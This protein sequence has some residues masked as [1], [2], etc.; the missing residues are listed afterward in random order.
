MAGLEALLE[1]ACAPGRHVV[2]LELP[3][4]P[5]FNGFGLA[6]RRLAKKYGVQLVPKRY[7][8]KVLC[9]PDATVDGLHL[10]HTGHALMAE[11]LWALAEDS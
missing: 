1:A 6:Q 9:A 5:L 4:P 7:F 10:S 11:T 3:L 2:M 8:G